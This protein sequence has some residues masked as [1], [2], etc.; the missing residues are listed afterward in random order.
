MSKQPERFIPTARFPIFRVWE[1]IG[2]SIFAAQFVE[3][4]VVLDIACGSGDSSGYL[5]NKG[6]KKVVGADYSEEA[7]EYARRHYQKEGLHFLRSDAQQMQFANESFDVVVSLETIEHL[8]RY[9]DFLKECNRVLKPGGIF[10]CSSINRKAGFGYR[11]PWHFKEFSPEELY[12]LI[13]RYF[14]EVELY[15]QLYFGKFDILKKKVLM[16]LKPIT[17]LIPQSVRSP[18]L[19]FIQPEYRHSASSAEVDPSLVGTS[20]ETVKQRYFPSRLTRDSPLAEF[21]IAV[22]RKRDV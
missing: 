10:V 18:L 4:K 13:A 22:A 1:H 8:E 21:T 16:R 6:A 15:G 2:R 17:S 5:M 9:E 11:S 3:G 14:V 7:I 12:K 20:D 19:K